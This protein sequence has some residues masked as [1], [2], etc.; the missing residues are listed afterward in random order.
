[1]NIWLSP[2]IAF[3]VLLVASLLLS[4]VTA[5]LAYKRKTK[6]PALEESYTG[7]EQVPTHRVRPDY[8]QFFPFAFFFTIL[9]VVTLIVATV[10]TESVGSF[11][12]AVIFLLG[13]GLGLFVLYRR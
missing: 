11:T 5:R 13:A 2:P 4:E 6:A 3:L 7:G 12:I 8:A 9:H 10:P 1:M